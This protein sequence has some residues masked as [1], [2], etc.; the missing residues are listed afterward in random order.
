MRVGVRIRPLTCKEIQQ[1]GKPSLTVAPP[2]VG[3]GQRQFT[4]D[5]VFDSHL[6]QD[7]LYKSVSAPLLKSF[8]DGYNAT[9]S[10]KVVRA[11]AHPEVKKLSLTRHFVDLSISL[12]IS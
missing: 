1:G 3:I 9:V 4:F 6:G 8:V 11:L 12:S 2:S 7:I 10:F 5:A